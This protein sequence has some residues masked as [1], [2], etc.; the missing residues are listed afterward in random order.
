[1]R[2]TNQ[3]QD[4]IRESRKGSPEK[5]SGLPPCVG[6]ECYK[7]VFSTQDPVAETVKFSTDERTYPMPTPDSGIY[8]VHYYVSLRKAFDDA[9]RAKMADYDKPLLKGCDEDCRC[10]YSTDPKDTIKT[11]SRER[12]EATYN[13]PDGAG[14]ATIW[15]TFELTIKKTLGTCTRRGDGDTAARKLPADLIKHLEVKAS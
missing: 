11:V 15:G 14:T 10:V 12:V 3:K 7:C 1:M 13:Y 4:V 2:T 8:G 5:A 6:S 9:A